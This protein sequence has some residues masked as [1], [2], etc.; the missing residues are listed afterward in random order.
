ME[1]TPSNNKPGTRRY[2]GRIL[3]LSGLAFMFSPLFIAWA[4]TAPGHNMWS[5][6]DS[7]SGG[8]AIWGML[9]T[10]PV[11]F[12]IIVTGAVIGIINLSR[13]Q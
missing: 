6:G 2:L 1:D 11:G 3:T 8:S 7:Q 5:E 12:C 13:K 9:L 10:L 4:T